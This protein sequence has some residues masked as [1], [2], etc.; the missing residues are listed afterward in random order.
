MYGIYYCLSVGMEGMDKLCPTV[1]VGIQETV[2]KCILFW[3]NANIWVTDQKDVNMTVN[4]NDAPT[5]SDHVINVVP[6]QCDVVWE[7]PI[8]TASQKKS[9]KRSSAML[10]VKFSV[11]SSQES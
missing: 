2:T 11:K 4:S 7:L 8:G 5:N 9:P 3:I 10:L 1:D 6:V